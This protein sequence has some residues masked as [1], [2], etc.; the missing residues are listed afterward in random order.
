MKNLILFSIISLLLLTSCGTL[1]TTTLEGT[2][3]APYSSEIDDNRDFTL[4]EDYW[5]MT[6]DIYSPLFYDPF[7]SLRFGQRNMYN[8]YKY[9]FD[10]DRRYRHDKHYN[11][12]IDDD[13]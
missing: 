3:S 9:K 1:E 12:N 8:N 4:E 5:I 10:Y 13:H 2:K 11:P 7:W 6:N